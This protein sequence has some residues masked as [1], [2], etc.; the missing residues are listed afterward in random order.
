MARAA[1]K[2]RP[3]KEG[4]KSGRDNPLPRDCP[5]ACS[6]RIYKYFARRTAGARDPAWPAHAPSHTPSP[7]PRP[8]I[9]MPCAPMDLPCQGR[10]KP[11]PTRPPKPGRPAKGPAVCP[12]LRELL[13]GE[14][15]LPF[16][17]PESHLFPV[18]PKLCHA[19]DQAVDPGRVGIC[20]LHQA[21]HIFMNLH[22]LVPEGC[23]FFQARF[24]ELLEL[25]L[26]F[27][28]DVQTGPCP[29]APFVSVPAS[30]ACPGRPAVRKRSKA[31]APRPGKP[32]RWL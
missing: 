20:V 24:A 32:T 23:P 16:P 30:G 2:R 4:Q 29:S 31:R 21:P 26:L 7:A 3:G 17:R 9:P 13:G 11:G 18:C 8:P 1:V 10:A 12:H 22:H 28:S 5:L 25:F 14:D 19:V 6:A 15:L 27:W